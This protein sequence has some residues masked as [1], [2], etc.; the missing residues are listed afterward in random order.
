MG[1]GDSGFASLKVRVF[2]DVWVRMLC[3]WVCGLGKLVGCCG[4]VCVFLCVC[5]CL[6]AIWFCVVV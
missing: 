2:V 6:R 5:L 4:L 1:L 3:V